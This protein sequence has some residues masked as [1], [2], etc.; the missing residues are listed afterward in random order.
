MRSTSDLDPVVCA[1]VVAEA[2]TWV[3]TPYEHQGRLKTR[4]VDCVGLIIGT[5]TELGLLDIDSASWKRFAGYARTPNP[6][7]MGEAMAQWL[8]PLD[9][10]RDEEAPDGCVGWFGWRADMPM[11]LAIMATFEGRRTMI[12]AF[13]HVGACVEHGFVAEWPGRVVSWWS[14]PGALKQA[15]PCNTPSPST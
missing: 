9:L 13:G 3:K 12:H 5:G 8:V 6:R 10:K 11:H 1:A 14:F 7:M 15:E 4:R 2:R